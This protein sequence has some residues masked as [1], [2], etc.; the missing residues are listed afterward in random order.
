MKEP[1]AAEPQGSPPETKPPL[2]EQLSP[3]VSLR[4]AVCARWALVAMLLVLLCQWTTVTFNYSGR[5]SGLFVTGERFPPPAAI[6]QDV[7]VH[8]GAGYDGQFYRIVAHDPWQQ[9][10]FGKAIDVERLRYQRILV[11]ALAWILGMGHDAWI[12]G[13]YIAVI[14]AFLFT[15]TYGLSLW[16]QRAGHAPAWALLFVAIPATAISL[17]RMTIDIATAALAVLLVVLGRDRLVWSTVLLAAAC[18]NRETGL[19]LVAAAV[20]VEL[21]HRAWKRAAVLALAILPMG[22]WYLF[23][24]AS[25]G[26]GLKAGGMVPSWLG[27]KLGLGIL[28]RLW[29]PPL[30][31]LAGSWEP[32][33][34]QLDRVA[35]V[36]M[37]LVLVLAAGVIWRTPRQWGFVEFGVL[38]HLLLFFAVNSMFFWNAV[39]GYARPFGPLFALLLIHF[40]PSAAGFALA[41]AAMV[42]VNL[43]V[44]FDLLWQVRGVVEGLGTLVPR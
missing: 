20:M 35:L 1:A 25:P 28:E 14:L 29:N 13:A 26:T 7:Y 4:S 12:D 11:P 8:P 39:H 32:L 19:V 10:G 3:E 38:L 24:P 34:R 36:G 9:R 44:G 23:L 22:I 16:L 37:L 42:M 30:Y 40:R 21:T 18:L 6:A 17:E 27:S 15:G 2:K 43:R 5:W 31:E 41:I 33:V